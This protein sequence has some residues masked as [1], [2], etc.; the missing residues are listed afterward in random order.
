MLR[1]HVGIVSL[2]V[3]LG[4]TQCG[5]FFALY[6]KEVAQ[7]EKAALSMPPG[8]SL[9][10]VTV[11]VYNH[12]EPAFFHA[13]FRAGR[14]TDLS[15]LY[16]RA[17][18][19][20]PNAEK[21]KEIPLYLIDLA[22]GTV[23]TVTDTELS[24]KWVLPSDGQD[25]RIRISLQSVALEKPAVVDAIW[26]R[27]KPLVQQASSLAWGNTGGLAVE[28]FSGLLEKLAGAQEFGYRKTLPGIALQ[29]NAT[30][31]VLM[32]LLVPTESDGTIKQSILQE[33][34]NKSLHVEWR[35]GPP[36]VYEGTKPY[37]QLPYF[38]VE[39]A[40]S[41]YL[42]LPGLLPAVFDSS[43]GDVSADVLQ[44]AM[45]TLQNAKAS[46][47]PEQASLELGLHNRA[48]LYLQEQEAMQAW[49]PNEYAEAK[50]RE[51][52]LQAINAY[53]NYRTLA[54]QQKENHNALY[55]ERFKPRMDALDR[56]VEQSARVVP[57]YASMEQ[58]VTQ[59]LATVHPKTPAL[60]EAD[61]ER[62]LSVLY[63]ILYWTDR[64]RAQPGGDTSLA[65]EV[66][67]V[68]KG[69]LLYSQTVGQIASI[70]DE[71]YRNYHQSKVEQLNSTKPPSKAGDQLKAELL[72]RV[73][74]LQCQSCKKQIL[75]A[76]QDYETRQSKP[77]AGGGKLVDAIARVASSLQ[78][79]RNQR[80]GEELLGTYHK[81]AVP[82]GR[83]GKPSE[84]SLNALAQDLLPRE[85]AKA[86]TKQAKA[87][88]AA[89]ALPAVP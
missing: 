83:V 12:L 31:G 89:L 5:G 59:L 9:P 53:V 51:L 76:C 25:S 23:D 50:R 21:P 57:F 2:C 81:R 56:C 85:P 80:A 3:L 15:H 38:L 30:S 7:P 36:K 16:I 44:R 41:N 60:D 27:T 10:Y 32:Y 78:E 28:M 33:I 74:R 86:S 71:L 82:D 6:P 70:E 68:L 69:S 73:P 63:P 1:L 47:S 19:Q 49:G 46:L 8:S 75:L 87:V 4:A 42:A 13:R 45:G 79:T 62:R 48:K 64:V 26:Q 14:K 52:R 35:N 58:V 22:K 39:Y 66:G 54:L 88:K 61:K 34:N 11:R 17:E 37:E 65:D 67:P 77:G 29:K 18:Y 55:T 72:R 20:E 43:C 84:D 40:L 24:P